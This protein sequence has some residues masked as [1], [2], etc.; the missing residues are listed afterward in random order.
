MGILQGKSC[1]EAIYGPI[2]WKG[3]RHIKEIVSI[4][5][6]FVMSISFIYR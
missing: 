1:M 6:D 3:L 4:R 2:G 5:D